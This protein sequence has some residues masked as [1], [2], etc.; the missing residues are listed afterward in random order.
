ML[1][2]VLLYAIHDSTRCP[3]VQD[4][5]SSCRL[6]QCARASAGTRYGTAGTTSGKAH[7]KWAFSEAAV[8]F[9]SDHPAAPT[10][11]ARLAQTHAQGQAL[12]LLAQ[13]LARAVSSMLTRPG[14]CEQ[15]KCFQRYTLRE[16][17][18]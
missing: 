2:L 13:Q 15:E 14:A 9:L 6:V 3:R 10:Y 17:S 4:C 11:L 7:L 18:G 12:T 16:G 1:R 5:V 8:W